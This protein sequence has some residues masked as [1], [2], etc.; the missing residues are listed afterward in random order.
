MKEKLNE[1]STLLTM[2]S[3]RGVTKDHMRLLIIQAQIIV[4]KLKDGN[5]TKKKAV[6]T[7]S[8]T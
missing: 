6:K 7:S 3:T 5:E 2:A 8:K 1:L 4:Q